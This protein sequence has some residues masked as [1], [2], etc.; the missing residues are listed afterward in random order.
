[1]K[2]TTSLTV[3]LIPVAMA[4]PTL[5]TIKNYARQSLNTITDNYLFSISLAAFT[6]NRNALNPSTLDWSSDGCTASPDNPFGF[7]FVR[8]CNRHDFGYQNYRLQ[9]RFT[10]SARLKIDNNFKADLYFLCESESP[11]GVCQALANVYYTFVRAFG[12]GDASP[13]KRDVDLVA[14]Y[15]KAVKEYDALVVEAQTAGELPVL[16]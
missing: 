16:Q 8:G 15:E 1:M 7:H 3:A 5:D 12:G 4:L 6:A 11:K 14:E 10:E 2:L 13:G 9:T